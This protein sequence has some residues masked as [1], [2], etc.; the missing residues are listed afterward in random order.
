MGHVH[1]ARHLLRAKDLANARYFRGKPAI[2]TLRVT[3]IPENNTMTLQLRA[4][5]GAFRFR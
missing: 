4:E 1:A 5:A 3:F 2:D